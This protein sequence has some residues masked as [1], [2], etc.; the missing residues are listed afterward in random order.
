M[1]CVT[2]DCIFTNESCLQQ[3]QE[4]ENGWRITNEQTMGLIFLSSEKLFLMQNDIDFLA[5]PY[6]KANPQPANTSL[7]KY[8][9]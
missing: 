4:R 3:F 8:I 7:L 9:R 6:F 1:L 2:L 5:S